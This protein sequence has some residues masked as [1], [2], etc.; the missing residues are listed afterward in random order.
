MHPSGRAILS[1]ILGFSLVA[2]AC[3]SDTGDTVATATTAAPATTVA[4]A[5]ETTASSGGETTA[6][7]EGELAGVCP[8]T[9]VIQT[10]WFPESEHGGMYEMVGDDYVIDGE[11]QTTTGSLMASGVDTGVDVQVRAGGPAIGYQNT[12]AQMYTDTDITLAYADT[13]SVA[14]FWDDAPVI[15]VVTPLDKNPQILMWDPEVHPNIHTIADLGETDVT[16]SVF[17]GGTWTQ[18][19]IAEGVLSEDQVDPSYDGSP[20]RFIAEGNI[21]QQGYASAEPWDYKHKYSEFGKDVRFQLVHDAGFEVYKSALSVRADEIDEMAPC[22]EKLVPI[23]QQ[24]Q[25][26]FM[27]GP[28]RTNAMIIEMVETIGSFWTYDEGIAAYSVQ[29][30]SDLGLVSNGPNGALGD[31]IDERT[32]AVL[33]QMRSAGMDIPAGLSASDMSTNRFIDYNI[34]LPGGAETAA[35]LAGVCPATVVIQT[36]W[37]P[38]SEHGGMYEMVGDDYVI[39]GENQTTTGS[40]MASGVDTGVDVQVRAGG[41]A[42]GYQNTVAQMYTDT[43]ITLAYA[44]TDSV[45]FFW[46]DAPVIQVVT[47]LDKN[48][49]ILMWDPEVHPNIHTIA[50]LGETD[51]TVSVF[52][53][54]TWTQLFIAEGVLSEDQVDPSYDGSPARFIAEGNI[55]QQGYASAEPWD[56]KHKYSEFGKDVRFQLVHDAGFEVYKSALSVRADEIDEMA[57]CLEKLV[58]IVQQAQ[59]DFMA[60]PGR[61]N[62]MIIE[63][64]ETIGSF[65]TYDEGI[66]AYSVQSQSDLGLVSNG[67]NGALG[68]FIDERTNAVLDQMRSAG[69][70]IPAGLSASDMSTNRFIDYNIGLPG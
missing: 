12:V 35:E 6:S 47:P 17:G 53:G 14:F 4:S 62:A 65:W 8:A 69:M 27:A 31:F 58:P 2:G 30:Q 42:I 36:D 64:V 3:G 45:A 34:G 23:V 60:G 16:V 25:V 61:T 7:S 10:D 37:F 41:P 15:Q 56:Y 29:S 26:D 33:D 63:M 57:P 50:D 21:A 28:G 18:L 11:N 67:P 54:G 5:A 40:L 22:L 39:D 70:D 51:V 49:Q 9:V 46:D 52:G 68:D 19:F 43:D 24:A 66:A 44:D 1:L 48:P 59:V 38:E 55:A 32:N 20:A 13:D